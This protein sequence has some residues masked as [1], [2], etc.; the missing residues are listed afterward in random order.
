MLISVLAIV[1]IEVITA[2]LTF[3]P[4]VP[5]Q[6]ILILLKDETALVYFTQGLTASGCNMP[7]SGG[8]KQ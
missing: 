7:H 6:G 1:I 5:F 4:R 2:K 3:S 8:S